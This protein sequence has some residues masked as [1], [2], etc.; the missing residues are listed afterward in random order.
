MAGKV[1]GI[2]TDPAADFQHFLAFPPVEL[3]KVRDMGFYKVLASF[4]LVEV[5]PCSNRLG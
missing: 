5:R 3:G 1:Y 2:R 4:N